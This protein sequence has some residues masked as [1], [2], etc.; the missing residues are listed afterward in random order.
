[1]ENTNIFDLINKLKITCFYS[2]VTFLRLLKS[3]FD[4]NKIN[5][6]NNS[7]FPSLERI[8]SCGEPLAH[9][10]GLWAAEFFK[11]SRKA[12]VNTYFQTET[13]GILVAPRDEDGVPDDYSSVGKPREELGLFIAKEKFSNQKLDAENI[14]PNEII[15]SNYWEGIY[16]EIQSDRKVNYFTSEGFYRLHDVGYFDNEGFL[17]IGGR[18]DDVINTAG[19][20]ISSSEIESICLSIK[21]VNE[22]CAVS[23][24]D[25]ILG[26]KPV[27]FISLNKNKKYEFENIHKKIL[28]QIRHNLSVYHLPEEIISFDYLPKTK[29]GKIQ[30]RI[31]REIISK[32]IID[33]NKDYSTLS[34]KEK[35]FKIYFEYIKE[36]I[37]RYT[38]N[39]E[40][41]SL[42]LFEEEFTKIFNIEST[43]KY[44][45]L[46]V[47]E[48]L[49]RLGT[50]FFP[51]DLFLT[52]E[53]HNSKVIDLSY[54]L[55]NNSIKDIHE[56]FCDSSFKNI[57][58][59]KDIRNG[60]L[61]ID[62]NNNKTIIIIFKSFNIKNNTLK[63]NIIFD[64]HEKNR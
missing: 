59:F 34:N 54:R 22:A 30:R 15:I 37:E 51:K 7:F 38:Y 27:L 9:E 8:G 19:H 36:R 44:F 45:I 61:R 26:E 5:N 48:K 16:K 64:N 24:N 53:L 1:M 14:D 35:F 2:S 41:F 4:E 55:E 31:M 11:P 46:I 20:R 29:S 12:I 21:G 3:R 60:C 52:F 40:I 6:N 58:F 28:D 43:I 50:E 39:S 47:I 57:L 63:I 18:S 17:Y 33:Q 42:N 10:V 49:Y 23:K 62:F 32:L 13:G 25:N 56:K